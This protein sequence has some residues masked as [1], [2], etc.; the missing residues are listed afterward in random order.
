MAELPSATPKATDELH[1]LRIA[2]VGSRGYPSTYGGFETL[3]RRLA[4]FLQ[5]RGHSVTVYGRQAPSGGGRSQDINGVR[6]VHPPGIDSKSLS[7]LSFGATAAL[8][9]AWERPDVAL[10]L[11]VA[12][13]FVL[14]ILRARKVPIAVNVDGI[15]WQRAKWGLVAR[16]MFQTGAA[17]TARYADR[18]IA[19]AREIALVWTDLFNVEPV[20]IPYGAD[21]VDNPSGD[22][23][24]AYGLKARRYALV[25]ARLVPENNVDLFLDAL[26]RAEPRIPAVVV[27]AANYSTPLTTRLRKLDREGQVSWLGHL[28]DQSLLEQLWTNAGVYF[29]G[30]SVGGTNPALLQALGCGAP[31]IAV[32]TKYNREVLGREEQLIPPDADLLASALSGVLGDADIQARLSAHGKSVVAARY[33]WDDVCES[34]ESALKTLAA[35]GSASAPRTRKPKWRTRS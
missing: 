27:G 33:R 30:H 13:G 16:R 10:V 18:L 15:E 4:P 19:D 28:D 11:N 26:E 6:V 1:P 3:V 14:P 21:I 29:H 25:V 2:I 8:H 23:L 31:T 9:V 20:F 17:L 32:S 22:R 12:N 34:Y 35:R 5:A 24:G 7:T